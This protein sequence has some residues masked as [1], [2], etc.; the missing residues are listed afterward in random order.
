MYQQKKQTLKCSED[1]ECK[2][3]NQVPKK[4]TGKGTKINITK[5]ARKV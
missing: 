2:K 3:A 4:E 1:K 5:V